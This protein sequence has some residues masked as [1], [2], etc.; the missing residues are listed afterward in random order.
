MAIRLVPRSIRGKL[1][2]TLGVLMGLILLLGGLSWMQLSLGANRAGELL[3][4]EAGL[5]DS[6]S[7]ARGG[8]QRLRRFEKESLLYVDDGVSRRIAM[9][10]FEDEYQTMVGELTRLGELAEESTLVRREELS[11]VKSMR[12]LLEKYVKAFRE[13][14]AGIESDPSVN[15]QRARKLMEPMEPSVA[16]FETTFEKARVG[17]EILEQSLAELRSDALRTEMLLAAILGVSLLASLVAGLS[18]LRSVSHPIRVLS[19]YAEK[20][21]GGD[22]NA[23]AEGLD[24]GEM[25][26]LRG[27]IEGMVE[28]LKRRFGFVSGVLKGLPQ[29]CFVV[30]REERVTFIGETYMKLYE[31]EGEPEEHYGK[32]LNEFFYGDKEKDTLTGRCMRENVAIR[33]VELTRVLPSGKTVLVTMDVVPLHDLDGNLIGAFAV[34]VDLTQIKQTLQAVE[35]KNAKIERASAE[36]DAISDQVVSATSELSAQVEQA[37]RGAVAQKERADTTATAVDQ[38]SA[39]VVEVARNATSA[40][41]LAERSRAKAQEGA[42][43]VTKVVNN[44]QEATKLSANLRRNM[45]ELGSKAEGISKIMN[46]INDIADQTNLLAL[47][48][49]IEAARAGEA[50]RGFAVVADEVRKLAEKTVIATKEVGGFIAAIQ[51][52]AALSI[53]GTQ[54]AAASIE[55]GARLAEASGAALREIVELVDDTADQVRNIATASEEQAAA[56]EEVGRATTEINAIAGETSDVMRQA[57]RAVDEIARV[58]Q[59]LSRMIDEMRS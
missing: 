43:V 25:G 4:V 17:N 15:P 30:D 54:S 11:A 51:N 20:V 50:G 24:K 39:S 31:V 37:S 40:S 12:P 9:Q 56:S 23:T 33:D 6:L 35:E 27:V 57:A 26:R 44:I 22:W 14:M 32:K 3:R 58:A 21:A 10:R 5:A 49:A 45:D 18:L 2:S 29:P 46:V 1:I 55:E 28:E 42:E 7:R 13:V 8:L 48:A 41:E 34:L 53:E 19:E 36:V 52:S 38:M 47:N 16:E 59:H